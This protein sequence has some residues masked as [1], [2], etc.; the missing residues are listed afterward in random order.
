MLIILDT[1]VKVKD[2]IQ[3]FKSWAESGGGVDLAEVGAAASKFPT[4][5]FQ[6]EQKYVKLQTVIDTINKEM[7]LISMDMGEAPDLVTRALLLDSHMLNTQIVEK[8]FPAGVQ[9]ELY[10][11]KAK[12]WAATLLKCQ[13]NG[14]KKFREKAFGLTG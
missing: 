1:D 10:N 5:F 3:N 14:L 11:L 13:D 4:N 2:V 9:V 12:D 7:G 6:V 8:A